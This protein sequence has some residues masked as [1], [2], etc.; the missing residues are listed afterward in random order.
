MLLNEFLKAHKKMEEQA[1]EIKKL[2]P[3]L[4]Q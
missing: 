2:K 1:S 3:A 4:K